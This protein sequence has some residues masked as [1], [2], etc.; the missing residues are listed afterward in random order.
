LG[1][2]ED[3]AHKDDWLDILIA[4]A[5]L[6]AQTSRIRIGSGVLILPY[7]NPVLTARMLASLDHLSG[8]RIDF[9][10]GVGWLIREFQALGVGDAYD[11][12]GPYSNEILDV[13][14]TCWKG[15]TVQFKG[16]WFDIPPVIF[17]P[18]PLQQGGRVPIW[19]GSLRTTGAPIRR[20]AKYADYWH[21]SESD[22]E[23]GSFLTPERFKETGERLDELAGRKIPR[24]IRLRCNGDPQERIDLLHR[25][26]EASCVQA[27][28]SFFSGSPTF[29][30]LDR[31]AT[32]F[33]E[34]A[35]SLRET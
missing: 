3:H 5:H 4:M 18:V 20:V 13:I 19:V 17:D 6:A 30:E 26:A 14:L 22:P 29:A 1:I 11:E 31:A 15:G 23:G 10:V 8:G 35:A 7:R 32:R 25:Y 12:R 9:G 33:F 34:L 28:C 2:P 24:T 21:P 27:A 16:K